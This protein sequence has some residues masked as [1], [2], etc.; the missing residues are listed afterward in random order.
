MLSH[1]SPCRTSPAQPRASAIW[2]IPKEFMWSNVTAMNSSRTYRP[3]PKFVSPRQHD[4]ILR[5]A[6]QIHNLY[7]NLFLIPPSLHRVL[8]VFDIVSVLVF[9]RVDLLEV[10][11][12]QHETSKALKDICDA[13]NHPLKIVS[14]VRSSIRFWYYL[15]SCKFIVRITFAA[16][17]VPGINLCDSFFEAIFP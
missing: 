8:F 15:T 14:T 3:W 11:F 5:L 12:F 16:P 2:M 1:T 9:I 17:A 4:R 7:E 13:N 10:L 6:K